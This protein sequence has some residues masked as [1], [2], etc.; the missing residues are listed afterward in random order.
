[1]DMWVV[2]L[3]VWIAPAILLALVLLALLIKETRAKGQPAVRDAALKPAT[4]TESPP[5]Q[6]RMLEVVS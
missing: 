2:A 5:E 1:M 6:V 4:L 3:V